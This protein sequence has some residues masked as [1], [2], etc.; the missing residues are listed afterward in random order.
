MLLWS[1]QTTS[2]IGD[3]VTLLALPLIAALT[4]NAS[5][6]EIGALAAVTRIPV[7][8]FTLPAGAVVDRLRKRPVMIASLLI[9]GLTMASIPLALIFG[10]PY[11]AQLYV[12]AFI[13]GL[14][15][16]FFSPAFQTYPILLLGPERLI[17][18]NSKLA[19]SRS[20][21][22][23]AGPTLGGWLITLMGPARAIMVDAA[24]YL[25]AAVA[26]ALIRAPEPEPV[27]KPQESR[28]RT[29]IADGFRY[30]FG[31][32]LLR[33]LAV[34]G[35]I[36][37]FFFSWLMALS[38]VYMVRDLSWSPVAVGLALGI[39]G[40]GGVF[41]GLLA[42]P[43]TER[44]GLPRVLLVAGLLFPLGNLALVL[45]TPGLT[46]QVIVTAALTVEMAG[47]LVFGI[48][49]QSLRQLICPPELLGRMAS[50]FHWTASGALPLG[51]LLAGWLGTIIGIRATLC[52]AITGLAVGLLLL[53]LSR[54][55][56]LPEVLVNESSKVPAR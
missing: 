17:E 9:A 6:F 16:V 42:K 32:P 22:A 13:S 33:P 30:V 45:V 54:L 47:T 8:L 51:A 28:L 46:G 14:C 48:A 34:G 40:A 24:T 19:F 2:V 23:S 50:T 44:Y 41:G 49:S 3:E 43:L 7:L 21:S 52:V 5:T 1:G 37:S 11:M 25:L 4:L 26:I 53:W 12:V 36:I 55:R 15:E 31:H 18:G 20:A 27:P 38:I 29:E 39:S 10:G 56:T 35:A